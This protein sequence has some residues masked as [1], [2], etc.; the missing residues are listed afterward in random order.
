MHGSYC[1]NCTKHKIITISH[2]PTPLRR[3]IPYFINGQSNRSLGVPLSDNIQKL[4]VECDYKFD[5]N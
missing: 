3:V 1:T 4:D 2:F 5:I